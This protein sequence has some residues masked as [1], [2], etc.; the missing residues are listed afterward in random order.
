MAGDQ[1]MAQMR[2]PCC[3]REELDPQLVPKLIQLER[4]LGRRMEI[5]SGY[6][7][8]D[9][10]K[11]VGG[12]RHSFH[13]AGKAADFLVRDADEQEAMAEA[14]KRLGFGG[15]GWGSGFLHVDLGPER[16]WRYGKDG[17]A[18]SARA[19]KPSQ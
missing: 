6:R 10:N 2:C 16:E 5:T 4:T 14:A 11:A 18:V 15:I 19:K 3:Q 7:C 9:H 1:I 12:A 17:K 13:M 8:E